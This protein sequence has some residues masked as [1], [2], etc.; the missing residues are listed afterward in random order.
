MAASLRFIAL[1][2]AVLSVSL[3]VGC[4]RLEEA[5]NGKGYA[6]KADSAEHTSGGGQY[7]AGGF[8]AGN[9]ESW[10]DALNVRAKAQNEYNRT[11][12]REN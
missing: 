4:S 3:T 2:A 8:T 6:G 10:S 11:P 12:A 7:S 1:G 9:K 5:N